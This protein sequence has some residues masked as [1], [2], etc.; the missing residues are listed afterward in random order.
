LEPV[1]AE[2][3]NLPDYSDVIKNPMDFGLIKQKLNN[4]HYFSM[5]SF[6]DDVLLVFDNCDLY[7]GKSS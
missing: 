1:D 3:Y 2:L 7:N 4:N 6:V 5:Q